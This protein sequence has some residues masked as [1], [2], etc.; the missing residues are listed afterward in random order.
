MAKNFWDKQ[1]MELTTIDSLSILKVSLVETVYSNKGESSIGNMKSFN[2]RKNYFLWDILSTNN[3]T[4][5]GPHMRHSAF[6][7]S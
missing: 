4:I 3:G 7:L 6:D 2:Y 5:F 1:L